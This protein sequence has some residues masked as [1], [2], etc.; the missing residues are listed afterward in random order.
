MSLGTVQLYLLCF[1]YHRFRQIND[2]LIEAFMHLVDQYEKEAKLAAEAAVQRALADAA[3]NLKAAGLVLSLFIDTSIPG[4]APFAMVK[5]K[6][7]SLLEPDRFTLV[8]DY[9][10]HIAFDTIEFQW[11]HYSKSSPTFK[12]NLRQLFSDLEFAGRVDDAPLLEAVAF[13]QDLLRQGK[14]PRQTKPSLFPVK[15]IPKSLQRYLLVTENGKEKTL[16]VDRYEFLIYRLLRNALEAGDVFVRDSTEFRRFEDDLIRDARWNDKDAVLR[17]IGAPMLLAPIKDT[18][19]EFHEAVE[20]KFKT[21]NQRIADGLN[22]HIKIRGP[23]EKRRWTLIYPSAEEPASNPFYDQLPGIG[24]ADLLWFV[25][26][27]TGFLGAFTH[28]LDRYVKHEADPREILAC[29]VAMGTNMGLWKMADVSGLDHASLMA[30]ARNFLRLETL[31]AANDAISNAIAVLPAFHLFDIQEEVHSSSDGQRME[32][33]I[34]TINA[35]HSPKYFGLQ[36]GVSSYTLVANH[37]PINAKIIGTHEHESHYVFDL[38]Y[39]NT[40][41]IKSGRH[42]TDTHGT[43]KVNFWTLLTFGHR[44]APR[45]RD[46]HKKIDTLVGFKHPSQYGNSLIKPSRRVYDDLIVKEWPNIQRIMA[47]LAQK[48]ATQATIVRK[49]SSYTR[50]NKTKKALWEL[51]NICRTLYILDYIDDVELRQIVQK[52][53]NRGE[54]YHRFRRAVAFVNGGKFRVQTEAEQQIWNECSRLITNAVIYYNTMLLSRVYEQKQTANDH[55]A[56]AIIRGMSPVAWQHVNLF[57]TFEFSQ[58]VLDI[59]IDALVARYA[60]P[61]YWSKVLK[62]ENEK[63]LG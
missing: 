33:Q 15:V 14:S 2:N 24:I 43:N 39:N 59:D 54:A 38:L 7:F 56:M 1:A 44:F 37:V 12:R 13:L 18:L 17:E 57:G 49:L 5:E 23:D 6:A 21:V 55:V 26:T 8:S 48:D 10:R 46:L 63:A 60:D 47:S 25:A 61:A 62:E 40:S 30:T 19:R 3:E 36:K 31:H 52:A 9:M 28:V 4:D 58:E 20:T 45:Y 53:L 42:S 34:N 35:R 16:E 32:T 27:T 51:D 11:A 41:D 29:V 50:Q 22:K